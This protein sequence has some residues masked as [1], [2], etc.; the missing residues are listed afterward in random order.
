MLSAV[1]LVLCLCLGYSNS[2]CP[3]AGCNPN[4][5]YC[6]NDFDGVMKSNPR[7]EYMRSPVKLS[8]RGC[9]ANGN[10]IVC[11]SDQKEAVEKK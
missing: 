8:N 1:L 4:R 11:P 6:I 9:L 10:N 2:Q 7:V 5:C 3:I